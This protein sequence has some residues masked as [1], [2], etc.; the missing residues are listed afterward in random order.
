MS[1]ETKDAARSAPLGILYAIG[2]AGV[3]GFI[4]MLAVN[5]CVQDFQA[6][7]VDTNITPQMTK[8]FLDGVGYNLTVF[9]CVIVMGAMFFSGSALTLGSSR[10]AYA[11]ARD[12]AMASI[13][14]WTFANA[15]K[16]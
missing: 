1:E 6:Q 13:T 2:T 4:F 9:F 11:F 12:Q 15:A 14:I 7:I 10:L 3:F 5:F 16:S 8:V